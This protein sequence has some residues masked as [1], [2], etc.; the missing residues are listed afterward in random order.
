MWSRSQRRS[1]SQT[2]IDH[3]IHEAIQAAGAQ[4]RT[5]EAFAHLLHHVRARTSM[6]RPQRFGGRIET[7]CIRRII[8]GLRAMASHQTAWLRLG[9]GLVAGW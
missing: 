9:R 5:R 2:V 1:S 6:L 4:S 8:A 7:G 3:A